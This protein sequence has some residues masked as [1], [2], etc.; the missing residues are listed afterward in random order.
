MQNLNPEALALACHLH[1]A[2]RPQWQQLNA[3]PPI[4]SSTSALPN[5]QA[6]SVPDD[7]RGRV[8]ELIVEA[9]DLSALAAALAS[10]A[11]AVV[12]DFDD[13]FVPS[14]ANLQTAYSALALA[15][16]S[17]K[18]LLA[19]PRA[20]YAVNQQDSE[21]YTEGLD[22]EELDTEEL[23]IASLCNLSAVITARPQCPIHL[24]IP[25]LETLAEAQFWQDALTL[26]EQFLDL[27][28]NTIKVCLQIETF[29]GVLNADALLYTLRGR[30][31]GLNA[32]RWDYVFSLTKHLGQTNLIALPPRS[33]LTMNVDAMQAYAEALVRV[34]QQRGA[35]AVGG[36]AAVAPDPSQPQLAL[37]AVTEDKMREASQGFTAAW[38]GLPQL[39]DA[40]RAGFK[41]N[42]GQ[43][44]AKALA[45]ES[46]AQTLQ[47]L[48]QLPITQLP[49]PAALAVF[50]VQ[51]SIGVALTVFE[52]W[53]AGK[54]VVVRKG[55]IEDTATA[56]LARAQLWQWVKVNALLDDE[57]SLTP[58]RYL[59][60]RRAVLADEQRAAQ[61]LDQLVLASN[62]PAYFPKVAQDLKTALQS[63]A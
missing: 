52:A 23:E 33:Q 22:T 38:A 61:L 45:P 1:Q 62:A 13:T 29:A 58:Q 16:A 53:F 17:D 50:D 60:E 49:T 8:V 54:G 18:P 30:A 42:L 2:L 51:E 63:G 25:K 9:S 57:T 19:R 28:P 32:G 48:T 20:L 39:L 31:Y 56:E 6:S 4:F 27:L 46:S 40:V 3:S 21:L 26:T 14:A 7:L 11:D 24:Y 55:R 5:Y 41:A 47:R 59:Q 44:K 43:G 34:C 36:T 35:E 37:K 10:D 15:I 12:L